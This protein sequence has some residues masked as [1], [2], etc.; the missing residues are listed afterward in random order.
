M[1]VRHL[2]IPWTPQIVY[3]KILSKVMYFYVNMKDRLKNTNIERNQDE[4]EVWKKEDEEGNLISL[5]KLTTYS[6]KKS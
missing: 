1:Y 5:C 6:R 4:S 3:T 2:Q